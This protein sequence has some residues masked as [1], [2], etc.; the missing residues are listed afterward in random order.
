MRM[1]KMMARRGVK[2]NSFQTAEE[3]AASISD[4]LLQHDV[5]LFTEYYERARFNESVEDAQ[6]L[7]ELYEEMAGRR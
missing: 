4:P 2:K 7:P 1:L 5:A 6:R 3:F